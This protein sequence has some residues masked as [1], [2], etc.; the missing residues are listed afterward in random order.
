MMLVLMLLLL[1]LLVSRASSVWRHLKHWVDASA[2]TPI[3]TEAATAG[4]QPGA[5]AVAV[6]LA[7]LMR[8]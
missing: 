2:H 3:P 6:A 8:G 7:M 4:R 1:L 5:I